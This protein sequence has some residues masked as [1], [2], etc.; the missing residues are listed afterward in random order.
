MLPS[1]LT[2]DLTVFLLPT[3]AVLYARGKDKGD[4]FAGNERE[5]E[6]YAL[7]ALESDQYK[8]TYILPFGLAYVDGLASNVFSELIAR[9]MVRIPGDLRDPLRCVA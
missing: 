5:S 8:P 4:R 9:G 3:P 6:A 7:A 2:P 1:T